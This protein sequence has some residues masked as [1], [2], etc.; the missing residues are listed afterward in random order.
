MDS[1]IIQTKSHV[2]ELTERVRR[3]KKTFDIVDQR[4]QVSCF[5]TYRLLGLDMVVGYNSAFQP[6]EHK[7]SKELYKLSLCVS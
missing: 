5:V 2:A 7:S 3:P 6:C 4:P 1:A